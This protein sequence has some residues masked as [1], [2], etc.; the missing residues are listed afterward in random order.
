M[1]LGEPVVSHDN[2]G[3]ADHSSVVFECFV[4]SRE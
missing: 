3:A 2:P 1:K 4:L